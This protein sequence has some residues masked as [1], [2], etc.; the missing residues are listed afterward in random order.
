MRQDAA[1]LRDFYAS[2]VGVHAAAM[3]AKRLRAAWSGC[4]SRDV[5]CLGFPVAV[6]SGAQLSPRRMICAA[7]AGQGAMR[8]P[9][10][11]A[12]CTVLADD[13]RLPFI[14][15]IFD[16]VLIMHALEEAEDQA[17]LLR[18][19]WR[20][21]APEGRV[22]VVVA[23]RLGAWSLVDSTPFGH[24]RPYSRRQLS[25]LLSAALFEPTASSRAVYAPPWSWTA[26]AAP[27][28]ERVGESLW[29]ALGG[30]LMMEAVKRLEIRPSAS[31]AVVRMKAA[32]AQPGAATTSTGSPPPPDGAP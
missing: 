31:A 5:L 29:P 18:E 1:A 32:R 3:I 8:W 26:R 12:S 4:D 25:G 11:A 30:V 7:P 27:L 22:I 9:A 15:A 21:M 10:D 23:N 16:R 20:V 28:F 14:D 6:A 17:A 24:G 13:R 2:P 19:V